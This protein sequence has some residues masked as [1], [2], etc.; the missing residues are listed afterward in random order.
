[1]LAVVRYCGLKLGP[2]LFSCS[3]VEILSV[4]LLCTGV[5][6]S[7]ETP[8]AGAQSAGY[9][10][11]LERESWVSTIA[12]NPYLD[13]TGDLVVFL[14]KPRGRV[15]CHLPFH[16]KQADS[17]RMPQTGGGNPSILSAAFVLHIEAWNAVNVLTRT[18]D[19]DRCTPGRCLSYQ[20]RRKAPN[21]L[22]H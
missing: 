7:Q 6:V 22:G 5:L 13:T 16:S 11:L 15:A 9:T 2:P 10:L 18:E 19:V 8:V 3:L 14:T 17:S 4:T 21:S 1:M 12:M 20:F